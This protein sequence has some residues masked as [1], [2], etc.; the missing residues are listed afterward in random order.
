MVKKILI[1]TTI[2]FLTAGLTVNAGFLDF[3]KDI[4][5][6]HAVS[7]YD[8]IE[9]CKRFVAIDEGSTKIFDFASSSYSFTLSSIDNSMA[10]FTL[11]NEEYRLTVP[12]PRTR[13][14]EKISIN[15]D[16]ITKRD[17]TNVLAMTLS[18]EDEKCSCVS[19]IL[20]IRNN[21]VNTV[22]DGVNDYQVSLTEYNYNEAAPSTSY[23]SYKINSYKTDTAYKGT[24]LTISELAGL[25]LKTEKIAS[26]GTVQITIDNSINC[27]SILEERQKQEVKQPETEKPA[28]PIINI[29][30]IKLQLHESKTD[31][32]MYIIEI[33]KAEQPSLAIKTTAGSF[34]IFGNKIKEKEPAKCPEKT[35]WQCLGF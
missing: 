35:F 32:D 5:T 4:F 30:I 17:S 3:F 16:S 6:G 23:V 15:L 2:L 8:T 11:N 21:K 27:K 1:L 7:G 28:Q 26:D 29:G 22:S 19:N 20:T 31:S 24:T 9:G 18:K 14:D 12:S 34:D 10:R 13:M 33:P 25:K